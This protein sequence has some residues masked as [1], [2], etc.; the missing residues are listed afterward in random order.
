[1]QKF[2]LRDGDEFIRLG[3][4]LKA[5]GVAGSGVEAKDMIQE[6]GGRGKGLGGEGKGGEVCTGELGSGSGGGATSRWVRWKV[7]EKGAPSGSCVPRSQK[8]GERML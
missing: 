8:K 6:G 7:A 2:T 3:Q 1:M 5:A 4:V